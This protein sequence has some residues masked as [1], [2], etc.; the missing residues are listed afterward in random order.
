[1]MDLDSA[2]ARFMTQCLRVSNEVPQDFQDEWLRR[3]GLVEE[4][5]DWTLRDCKR[6]IDDVC[7]GGANNGGV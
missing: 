5:R 1:M 6:F 4:F 2:T 7:K 3:A